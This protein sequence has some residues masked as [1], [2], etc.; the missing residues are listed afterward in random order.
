MIGITGQIGAGKSFVGRLLRERKARVIDADVAVHH[1]YRD[2]RSLREA[3]E[4]ECRERF[5]RRVNEGSLTKK[6][7]NELFRAMGM[8]EIK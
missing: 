1:L 8:E 2:C 3:V 5:I 6:E 7:A 4:R